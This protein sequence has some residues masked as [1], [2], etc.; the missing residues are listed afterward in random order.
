MPVTFVT[1]YLGW[2]RGPGPARAILSHDYLPPSEQK[3]AAC[4]HERTGREPRGLNQITE[5][6]KPQNKAW[7][8]WGQG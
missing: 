4:Q 2:L 1:V 5:R 3:A 6:R 8:V 7:F